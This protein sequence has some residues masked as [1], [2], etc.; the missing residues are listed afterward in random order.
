MWIGDGLHYIFLPR[1]TYTKMSFIKFGR[2]HCANWDVS[3]LK[4]EEDKSIE[5]A[6][7]IGVQFS[8]V[9]TWLFCWELCTSA[10]S[11]LQLSVS[12]RK[13]KEVRHVP[14]LRSPL[15]NAKKSASL[16]FHWSKASV[17]LVKLQNNDCVFQK[18]IFSNMLSYAVVDK[19]DDHLQNGQNFPVQI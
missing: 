19:S 4:R 1:N 3:L 9:I 6:K 7:I 16:K 12:I 14:F 2:L 15:K 8:E 10:S 18:E 13:H 17:H 11:S 5:T